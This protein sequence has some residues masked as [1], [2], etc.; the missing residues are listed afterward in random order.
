MLKKVFLINYE[1]GEPLE[2]P[3]KKVCCNRY[4]DYY[5]INIIL[6]REELLYVFKLEN[7]EEMLYYD[8]LGAGTEIRNTYFFRLIAGAVKKSP[9]QNQP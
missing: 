3:M 8:K 5:E 6:D 1:D 9:P 4:F 7:G 2:M